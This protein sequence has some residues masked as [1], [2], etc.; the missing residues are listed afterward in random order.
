[1]L[2]HYLIKNQAITFQDFLLFLF[3]PFNSWQYPSLPLYYDKFNHVFLGSLLLYHFLF[4]F[5]YS[6]NEMLTS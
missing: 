4:D 1:M 6:D 2:I 5:S 3:N